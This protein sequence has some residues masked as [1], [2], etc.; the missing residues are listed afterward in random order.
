[1]FSLG[2]CSASLKVVLAMVRFVLYSDDRELQKHL[3][4]ALGTEVLLERTEVGALPLLKSGACHACIL[5]LG[6]G[7]QSMQIRME[8]AR[9]MIDSG[10]NVF[11]A[12]DKGFEWSAVEMVHYG[13][14]GYFRNDGEFRML[15]DQ[16]LRPR[17]EPNE[18]RPDKS[19]PPECLSGVADVTGLIGES[20]HIRNVSNMI[21]LVADLDVAVFIHGETGTGKEV[22]ARAIHRLGCRAGRPFVPVSCGAIP[23]TLIEAEL[24][25]HEKGAFTGT[26]GTRQ[27]NLEEAADGTLFFDEIA[28][29]SLP[30]QVKLLRVLQE[31]EFRR[32]GSNRLIPLRARLIFATHQ[33][34]EAKI[35]QGC[36]RRDLYY[37]M[38]VVRISVPPLRNRPDD[39]PLLAAHFLQIYSR[40]FGF[41]MSEIDSDSLTLLKEHAWPGN[42]R[43]LEHVIQSAVVVS[44]GEAIRPHHLPERFMRNSGNVLDIGGFPCDRSFDEQ[45]ANFKLKLAQSAVR[46]NHGNKTL[47][48]RSLNISRP[49]LH[50]L[51]RLGDEDLED[52][53]IEAGNPVVEAI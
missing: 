13:A 52:E 45:L 8:S 28:E 33:D 23:E 3:S 25:G 6:A 30:A 48:A 41:P 16:L 49:Y 12:A 27:G 32:L 44:R 26:V 14:K 1:M 2:S 21:R 39:I 38:D 24:F 20:Q 10:M 37:R 11:I 19:V 15:K 46:Q 18:L 50:R 43:E 34:L 42:V 4:I 31:C 9:R 40:K 35:E 22:I 36:F 29:L 7:G 51:L 17:T 53:F 47:A 5:H